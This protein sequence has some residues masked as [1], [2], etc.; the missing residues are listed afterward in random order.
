[1]DRGL[2]G[3]QRAGGWTESWRVDREL[4]GGQRVGG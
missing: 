3:G 4:E 2:E 1:M